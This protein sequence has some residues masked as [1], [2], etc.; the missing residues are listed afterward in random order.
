M[1]SQHYLGEY[2]FKSKTIQDGFT[3]EGLC[4]ATM[5]A[6][7][8]KEELECWPEMSHRRRSWLTIP[9]AMESCRHP[10]MR[11]ALVE[12]FSKW[13]A[14]GMISTMKENSGGG[15]KTNLLATSVPASAPGG[16]L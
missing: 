2:L 3:T 8:V 15:T 13:H 6:L 12:G 14:D 11:K 1:F 16:N 4:K 5:F 10:W 7:L 9:E